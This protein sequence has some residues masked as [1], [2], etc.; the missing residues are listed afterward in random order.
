ME[1]AQIQSFIGALVAPEPQDFAYCGASVAMSNDAAVIAVGCPGYLRSDSIDNA[2]GRIFVFN[3]NHALQNYELGY[4]IIPDMDDDNMDTQCG[5]S[6]SMTGD[7]SR[8]AVGCPGSN[9]ETGEV[10]IYERNGSNDYELF[11]EY[12]GDFQGDRTGEQVILREDGA[13]VM[14]SIPG[15]DS[16]RIEAVPGTGREVALISVANNYN[17]TMSEVAWTANGA[18][19]SYVAVSYSEAAVAAFSDVFDAAGV[20]EVYELGDTTVNQN[21]ARLLE[22]LNHPSPIDDGLY[23]LSLEWS[24]LIN[25][26]DYSLYIGHNKR[27]DDLSGGYGFIDAYSVR[28][29]VTNE[30]SAPAATGRQVQTPIPLAAGVLHELWSGEAGDPAN[31]LLLDMDDG[32]DDIVA[33]L[34]D[35]FQAGLSVIDVNRDGGVLVA[36]NGEYHSP[37]GEKQMGW[38][39]VLNI[40]DTDGDGHWEFMN[41]DST[42]NE[43][44]NSAKDFDPSSVCS[45]ATQPSTSPSPDGGTSSASNVTLIVVGVA[46]GGSALIAALVVGIVLYRRRLA[47][48][49]SGKSPSVEGNL[50]GKGLSRNRSSGSSGKQTETGCRENIETSHSAGVPQ[51]TGSS[52]D[53]AFESSCSALDVRDSSSP[54]VIESAEANDLGYFSAEQITSRSTSTHS[55]MTPLPGSPL[56]QGTRAGPRQRRPTVTSCD[57]QGYARPIDVRRGSTKAK[58]HQL[59][60]YRSVPADVKASSPLAGPHKPLPALPDTKVHAW[61]SLGATTVSGD[62]LSND[63]EIVFVGTLEDNYYEVRPHNETDSPG[64]QPKAEPIYE[65]VKGAKRALPTPPHID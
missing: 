62:N 8:I 27:G 12:D 35:A 13:M 23:G 61:G 22:R 9:E 28:T 42:P 52:R 45:N 30:R 7:G 10:L 54:D 31:N 39:Y 53:R 14:I 37:T 3:Y 17:G 55:Y 63:N 11:D 6:V 58:K 49:R 64:H 65:N 1:E 4:T 50:L 5:T 46:V 41:S 33:G 24:P 60:R 36:C 18:G 43:E 15:D 57:D 38:C 16:I 47:R 56:T 2:Q 20:V 21:D 51:S 48:Q 19:S 40:S 32:S 25:G 44:N 34:C 26:N 59:L 29:G